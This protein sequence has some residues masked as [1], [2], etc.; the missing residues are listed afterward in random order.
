M[1][2]S[3]DDTLNDGLMTTDEVC[4][5]LRIGRTKA[6]ELMNSGQLSST[7]IGSQR[8]VPRRAVIDLAARRYE[9]QL[10]AADEGAQ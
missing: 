1:D 6:Y 3:T 7:M 5:F 10:R 8:R 4:R 9:P 2:N